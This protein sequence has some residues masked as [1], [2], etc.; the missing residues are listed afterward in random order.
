M[1][2]LLFA[3][4]VRIDD[5]LL[6]GDFATVDRDI[7]AVDVEEAPLVLLLG[8]LSITAAAADRLAERAAFA[9]KVATRVNRDETAERAAELL[10]G[11]V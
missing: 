10:R 3:L 4:Y 5:L 8:W 11:L 2:D 9:R 1:E 7:A 6:A